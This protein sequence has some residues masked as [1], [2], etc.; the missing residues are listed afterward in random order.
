MMPSVRFIC[1]CVHEI[2]P[3]AED[4]GWWKE[5]ST[6]REGFLICV[7]HT[8]RRE[9]WRS[10]PEI[11]GVR[12][13]FADFDFAGYTP[14][15]VEQFV[16]WGKPLPEITTHYEPSVTQDMRDNRDPEMVAAER[17]RGKNGHS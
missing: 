6:D 11:Q 16:V 9:G 5:A 15:Q 12:G 17:A 1:G 14:L 13:N 4:I 10:L 8:A 7:A 2:L 3:D